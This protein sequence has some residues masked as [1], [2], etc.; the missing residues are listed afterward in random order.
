MINTQDFFKS[1]RPWSILKDGI[2]DYYLTPYTSKL[3]YSGA[4]LVIIDCFAGKGRFEDGA[5]GSP[6]IIGKHLKDI[7]EKDPRS[8]IKAFFIEKKYFNELA[9]NMKGFKNC[10][11]INGAYESSM[12]DILKLPKE[13]NLFMYIDPYGI[14]NLDFDFFDQLKN[15]G[16]HSFEFLINFNAFGFLRE[17]CN[18]IKNYCE[19]FPDEVEDESVQLDDYYSDEKDAIGNLDKIAGG[20]YWQGILKEYYNKN[21]LTKSKINML[22]AEEFF[23][24]EYMN[25]HR[26]LF[27]YVVN[28]PIKKKIDNIPK[29]RMI[30]GTDHE[31]GLLLMT[32]SM[33]TAW[34]K[35]VQKATGGQGILFEQ[36]TYPSLTQYSS[37]IDIKKDILGILHDDGSQISIKDLLVKMICLH[38]IVFS[39]KEYMEV[40]KSMEGQEIDINRFPPLTPK[41]N[42]PSRSYDYNKLSIF[43]GKKA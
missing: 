26:K 16:F 21:L 4:P 24:A 32:K 14:K 11:V 38:G 43:V 22:K 17:G 33:N 2:L 41:T 35:I 25:R 23:V 20:D 8:K 15:R 1:K 18:K 7:I 19:L 13:I 37:E 28:V 39:D 42:K 34:G 27:K 9:G 5:I 10:E 36:F 6:I 3:L 12:Q 40:I 29:Y 30:F 31:D